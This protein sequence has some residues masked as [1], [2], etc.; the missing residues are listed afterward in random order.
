MTG[1]WGTPL[2]PEPDELL[3]SYLIRSSHRSGL[4]P[5]AFCSNQFHTH[6]CWNRDLDRSSSD[7][8][9]STLIAGTRLSA[10]QLRHLTLRPLEETICAAYPGWRQRVG[11][12]VA[13]W[14]LVIGITHRLRRRMG[15][16]FCGTCLA[17]TP[18]LRRHWRLAFVTTCMQH[19]HLLNDRCPVCQAPHVPHRLDSTLTTCHACYADLRRISSITDTLPSLAQDARIVQQTLTDGLHTGTLQIGRL[20]VAIGDALRGI[21]IMDQLAERLRRLDERQAHSDR[22]ATDRTIE[23][24]STT[25]R[26]TAATQWRHILEHW[27]QPLHALADRYRLTQRHLLEFAPCPAW[28]H[29][30]VT[31]LPAGHARLG[32][33][34]SSTLRQRLRQ[35]HRR[36]PPQWRSTRAHLLLD[37]TKRT[38]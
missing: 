21:H 20:R 14:I 7:T 12:G 9:V 31:A 24:R 15:L 32:R 19:G 23:R 13:P 26:A 33:R 1:A 2:V 25:H 16:Q 10:T 29:P 6:N 5:S 28:M 30:A 36:R 34:S 22:D 17:D 3:T 18:Y 27:P 4:S 11:C 38:P 8:V 37:A 35:L